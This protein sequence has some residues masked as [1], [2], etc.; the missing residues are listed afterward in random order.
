MNIDLVFE[1]DR[2]KFKIWKENDIGN[3]KKLWGDTEV[4]K[5][6]G[7]PFDEK[8]IENRLRIEIDNNANFCIQYWKLYLKT[9][10]EFIGCCGFR[11]YKNENKALEMGFHLCKKYWGKGYATEAGKASLKYGFEELHL[12]K[13]YA[14]HNPNNDQSKKVLIK[15]GFNYIRDEY[16]GPTGLNH[17]IYEILYDNYIHL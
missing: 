7:G 3:A 1:S 13:I 16:Y 9:N 15:L 17:P 12:K 8:K 14:G 10:E 4:T 6:I 5:Y 11:P 2:L